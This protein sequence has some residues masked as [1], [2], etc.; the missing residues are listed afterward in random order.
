MYTRVLY[1]IMQFKK[2]VFGLKMK[3][4]KGDINWKKQN[5]AFDTDLKK[6]K[7]KR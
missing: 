5:V 3:Q 6:V 4:R 7:S 1:A 2:L